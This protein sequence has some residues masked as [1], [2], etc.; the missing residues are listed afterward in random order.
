MKFRKKWSIE[1]VRE[2]AICCE[3]YGWKTSTAQWQKG[4]EQEEVSDDDAEDLIS[5]DL[6]GLG[7]EV[8]HIGGI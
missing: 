1:V 2:P 8:I 5:S 4:S 7:C 6:Y 3:G